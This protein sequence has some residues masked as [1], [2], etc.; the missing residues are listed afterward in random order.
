MLFAT[1]SLDS[2][3]ARPLC[4]AAARSFLKRLA[5]SLS[6]L[7]LLLLLPAASGAQI[8][9][10][11][12][13][14]VTVNFLNVTEEETTSDSLP[15]YFSFV[16]S[17]NSL[18]FNPTGFDAA[19][20]G[21]AGLDN[22]GDR[23]TFTIQAHAGQAIPAITFFESGD[24]TLSGVGTDNTSTQVT[25]SGTITISAVDGAP[26]TPIVQPIALSF[27]PSGGTFG[28]ASDGGGLPIFNTSWTGSL[29]LNVA[30]ILSGNAVPF[31]TGATEVSIDLVNTLT[32]RSQAGTAAL[33]GKKDFG[34]TVVPEPS[35][36]ALLAVALFP[37]FALT[38]SRVSRMK[39][40]Q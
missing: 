37:F 27:T 12:F 34:F 32:A 11:S 13:S 20:S 40:H 30:S 5:A 3:C 26:I 39:R 33:I 14:G 4:R 24:T 25:S 6:A 21:A 8:N 9:Y 22:T 23:L 19:A 36:L 1:T 2:R 18:D 38:R 29:S 28:L 7:F 15:L 10:G 31:S 17:A 16:G 35:S